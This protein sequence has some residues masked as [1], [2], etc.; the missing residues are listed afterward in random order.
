MLEPTR[1]DKALR[2]LAA[3]R[4]WGPTPAAAYTGAAI[5]YPH[6]LAVVDERGSL[7]FEEVHRRTNALARELA[8]A[9]IREGDAVAI[10]CRNHRGF[11]DV[12]VACSKIGAGA[13]YLNTA[14]AAPQIADV[15]EREK[16]VAVIYD[17]EF[18][19]LIAAGRSRRMG[20]IAW[21]EPRARAEP[22]PP[23]PL[24]D[25]LIRHGDDSD[26]KAPAERGRVVIL[27]SG[28]TGTPKGAARKQP[29]SMEPV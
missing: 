22:R 6:R 25:D 3:L 12:T 11:I 16:P 9:G 23:D 27:T 15:L 5:R 1:P 28:T 7:T 26:L 19:E 2:S 21:S 17:E 4:R 24:L 20:F 10:M 8:G 18:G 14:F 29:D 13:L